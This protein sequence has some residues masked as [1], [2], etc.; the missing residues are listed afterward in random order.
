MY[1]FIHFIYLLVIYSAG[2]KAF[3]SK[4]HHCSRC[5]MITKHLHMKQSLES[6][7]PSEYL[8]IISLQLH[9][10]TRQAVVSLYTPGS[11]DEAQAVACV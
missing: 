4:D 6:G 8:G 11:R 3:I 5:T 2:N 10:L 1:L 9:T 7:T